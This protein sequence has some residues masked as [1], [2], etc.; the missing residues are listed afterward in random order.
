MR[1]HPGLALAVVGLLAPVFVSAQA[2]SIKIIGTDR[3]PV[4]YAMVTVGSESPTITDERGEVSIGKQRNKAVDIQVKRLGYRVLTETIDFPDTAATR[5][6]ILSRVAQN[7]EAAA[8]APGANQLVS[9]GFYSRYLQKQKDGIRGATFIG[10]EAIEARTVV[11]TTDLLRAVPGLT[12]NSD[13]RGVRSARGTGVRPQG[14]ATINN[15]ASASAN[16]AGACFMSVLI[17]ARRVCPAVGCH[18]V[19]ADDPPGSANEDHAV[20]IDKLVAAKEVAAVEVYTRQ[21][22]MPDAA[23]KAFEGCGVLMIWTKR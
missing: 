12:V 1:R 9:G 16:A 11:V 7:T 18:Y 13:S 5:T 22:G 10:P 2:S 14:G 21:D 17:D 8:N 3:Q 4:P 15:V 20:D 23:M 6:L 19:F